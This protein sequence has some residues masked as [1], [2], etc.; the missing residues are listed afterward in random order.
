MDENHLAIFQTA[1]NCTFMPLIQRQTEPID[2]DGT[3]SCSAFVGVGAVLDHERHPDIFE[4][5]GTAG[6]T[7]WLRT[8]GSW[9]I[10]TKPTI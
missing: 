4:Q 7:T 9:D 1:I 6:S 8:T 3:F 10:V 5:F 2:D